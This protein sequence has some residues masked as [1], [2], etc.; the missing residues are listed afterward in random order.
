MKIPASRRRSFKAE[1]VQDL[2][3]YQLRRTQVSVFKK[4]GK[5]MARN[6]IVPGHFSVLIL[7]QLNPDRTQGWLSKACRI[8]RSTMVPIID[9]LEGQ[10]LVK[11]LPNPNDQ[12][13]YR[14]RITAA[15]NRLIRQLGP[16][17]QRYENRITRALSNTECHQLLDLLRRLEGAS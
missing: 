12:R 6:R 9:Q 3:G 16:K 4:L 10:G 7:I 8:D 14:L 5:I 2:I 15:G 1:N 13:A 17:L 11:R